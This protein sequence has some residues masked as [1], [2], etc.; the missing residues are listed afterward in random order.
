MFGPRGVVPDSHEGVGAAPSGT[1]PY[2]PAAAKLSADLKLRMADSMML[3]T[4]R[5]FGAILW[6]QD[7]DLEG[8]E[9]IRY[10][11]AP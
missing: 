3:A 1:A 6:S 2:A 9:G 8:M 7:A 11:R 5:A 10:V 4:A